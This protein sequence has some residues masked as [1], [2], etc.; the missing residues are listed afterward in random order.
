GY[1]VIDTIK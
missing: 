1:E